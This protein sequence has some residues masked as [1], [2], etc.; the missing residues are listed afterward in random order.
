M[1]RRRVSWPFAT[2]RK[3]P[4]T[5]GPRGYAPGC[6]L[7]YR[8]AADDE[9]VDE[10]QDHRPDDRADPARRLLTAAQQGGCQESADERAGDAQQYGDNP[11][12]GITARHKELGDCTH[13]QTEQK[14]S[15]DVHVSSSGKAAIDE[16]LR[17]HTTFA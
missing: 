17:C 3:R 7:D 4:P 13:H 15:N 16:Q 9:A 1:A 14:P 6:E 10:Q 5:G 2:K 8:S 11:A 12:T